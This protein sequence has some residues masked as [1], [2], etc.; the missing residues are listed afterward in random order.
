V[1]YIPADETISVFDP[2][3]RL[4]SSFDEVRLAM[5]AIASD[6]DLPLCI[7]DASE[8][9]LPSPF[10]NNDGT[11][12]YYLLALREPQRAVL[13]L[14]H[15]VA[16]PRGFTLLCQSLGLRLVEAAGPLLATALA[17]DDLRHDLSRAAGLARRDALTGLANRLAWDEALTN[18]V[19]AG[20][21][22]SVIEVDCRGLKQANERHGHHV[23]DQL[24]QRT[25]VLLQGATRDG[26]LVARIG[27]DEFAVIL[28]D[29]D[30]ATAEDVVE[31]IRAAI[32]SE[33]SIETVKM[34]VAIGVATTSSDDL[35]GAQRDADS[36]MRAGKR[37]TSHALTA[38]AT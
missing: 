7:Q 1:L 15:T 5:A 10:S 23:G 2:N 37:A 29:S 16:A 17:R 12:A 24:L 18:H 21:P 14:A 11:I 20:R 13:L 35:A 32:D 26:D 9:E 4:Q 19:P 28:Y 25:A 34:G 31:R 33:P 22:V 38:T 8:R 30:E 6:A 36:R 3:N 27:G